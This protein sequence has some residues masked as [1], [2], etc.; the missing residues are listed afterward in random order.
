MNN[1]ELLILAKAMRKEFQVK[2]E[3]NVFY[4]HIPTRK[5]VIFNPLENNDQF[6]EVFEWLLGISYFN[7]IFSDAVEFVID[8][9]YK[10]FMADLEEFRENI[11]EIAVQVAK[12]IKG[13]SDE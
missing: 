1:T 7:Y 11:L 13:V 9:P 12:H 4:I 8:D 2:D 10:S 6:V 5:S 3:V